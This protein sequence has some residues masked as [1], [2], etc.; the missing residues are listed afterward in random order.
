MPFC[1]CYTC[2][3]KTRGFTIV[4]LLVVIVVIAILAAVSVVAYT[5]IQERARFSVMQSDLR[6]INN[7]IQLYYADNGKY[8]VAS[9]SASANVTGRTLNI[10]GLVPDYLNSM[11]SMPNDGRGGYYAYIWSGSG[12]EYK[13]VR[14]ATSA[15]NL[16]DIEQNQPNADLARRDTNSGKDRGWGYWS[17]GGSNL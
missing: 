16:P 3:M 12:A 15:A 8:P 7:A 11:P 17:N 9:S 6:T 2:Y 13:L 10:P 14:L 4:E 1:L 5:G